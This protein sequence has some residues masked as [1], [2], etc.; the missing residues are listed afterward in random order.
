MPAKSASLN[1]AIIQVNGGD[2]ADTFIAAPLDESMA[3]RAIKLYG[4]DG[5]DII[6]GAHLITGTSTIKGGNWNDRITSGMGITGESLIEGNNGSDIIYGVEDGNNE[7][8]F[9]DFKR[10]DFTN[11]DS[12][13]DLGG[14]DY[15]FGSHN[16]TG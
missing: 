11:D 5:D 9:G 16:L 3:Q 1:S 4:D 10:S 14:H 12:L 8:M 2:D 15:I 7:K 13:L 6:Q